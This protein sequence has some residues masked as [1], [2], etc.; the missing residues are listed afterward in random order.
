MPTPVRRPRVVVLSPFVDKS[1][2]TERCVAEQ[3]ERL[4]GVYEIH[5]YSSRVEDVDLSGITWHR[6]P[7]LR[8][9][10]LFAYIWWLC[11]NRFQR[12]RDAKFNGIAPDIIYSPGVNCLDADLVSVHV[13]FRKVREQMVRR[14]NVERQPLVASAARRNRMTA[15]PLILHRR[16]YYRLI[17]FLEN[18]VYGRDDIWLAAVSEK[19]AQD[20]RVHFGPKKHLSVIYHGVDRAK[21]NPQRRIELRAASRSAL[22]L[23]DEAFAILFIGNDWRNRGLPCLLEAVGIMRDPKV[24]V[25][26]AG[27]DSTS[28]Y[29]EYIEKIGLAGRVQ[30]L[31]PRGDVEFYY[32]AADAYAGPSLEDTFSLPPAE[33]MACGLPVI[34]TR[35]TGV[36]E[37]IHHGEDGLVLE[38]PA[39]AKTLSEWLAR[40]ASDAEWRER[41]GA[42]AAK[43]AA[44]YTWA[45]NAE[46]L[47]AAIDYVLEA[48]RMSG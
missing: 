4:S 42:A 23:T 24:R 17:E 40:L 25:L 15:S 36:S 47:R 3:I 14:Q 6:V 34:T 39:D 11:A 5:L 30:F 35:A 33:A 22:K 31:P 7:A 29:Q 21:F 13:L 19:G 28:G 16:I 32:A 8:G 2:G 27:T 26:V 41:M 10:H 12:W 20:I 1:H 46:E 45:R 18:K 38:D 43:T 48:R 37:I 9:P 44:K